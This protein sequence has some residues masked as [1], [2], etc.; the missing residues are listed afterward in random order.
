[1]ASRWLEEECA[2]MKMKRNSIHLEDLELW[3]GGGVDSV[4]RQS[5]MMIMV[6][7]EFKYP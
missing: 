7:C 6:L 2:L 3:H 5:R 4:G 1:M